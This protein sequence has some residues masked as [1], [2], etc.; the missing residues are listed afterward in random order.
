MTCDGERVGF[1]VGCNG[2]DEDVVVAGRRE[3]L[4]LSRPQAGI[5]RFRNG[6]VDA[7]QSLQHHLK[8]EVSFW[9]FWV[10]TGKRRFRY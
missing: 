7:V 5:F 4:L 1:R 6:E 9:R 2:V 10:Q 3:G 8:E